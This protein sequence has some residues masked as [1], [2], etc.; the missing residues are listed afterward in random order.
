MDRCLA[1][2]LLVLATARCQDTP[3]QSI[4]PV[5]NQSIAR[6]QLPVKIAS[7][8]I[9]L[10]M[11]MR[12]RW[13][14]DLGQAQLQMQLQVDLDPL[15]NQ[16][17][18]ITEAFKLPTD[19][20]AKFTLHNPVIDLEGFAISGAG[21]QLLA[22]ATGRAQS[23]SCLEAPPR[24]T[25][26]EYTKVRIAGIE[27]RVKVPQIYR[28]DPPIEKRLGSQRFTLTIPAMIDVVS[29]SSLRIATGDPRLALQGGIGGQL[30]QLLERLGVDMQGRLREL[31]ADIPT[32]ALQAQLPGQLLRAGGR[33][34]DLRF[35]EATG[36]MQLEVKIEVELG[37]NRLLEFPPQ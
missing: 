8:T 34:V 1:V 19:R 27:T 5:G 11:V 37:T 26:M 36:R 29:K 31:V 14:S 35:F 13:S 15:Q 10:P 28:C 23:W 24:C 32:E 21:N 33:I 18:A 17:K 6:I 20:C 22:T 16:V 4:A 2:L 7:A 12:S 25:R 3:A 9:N 30:Q